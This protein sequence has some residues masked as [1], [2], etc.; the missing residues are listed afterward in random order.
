MAK[1]IS[2]N[3]K[4]SFESYIKEMKNFHKKDNF[5]ICPY[6]EYWDKLKQLHD[7][8]IRDI[9]KTCDLKVEDCHN[10]CR[11]YEFE[12]KK[13]IEE[14][15]KQIQELKK[16]MN[17]KLNEFTNAKKWQEETLK[18]REAIAKVKQWEHHPLSK[19][20]EIELIKELNL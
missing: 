10:H 11:E 2:D 20:W 17:L 18:V 5:C 7:D 19:D 12:H 8:E 14:K 6:E 16:E 1:E 3:K 13:E 9:Q 4:K 15:D